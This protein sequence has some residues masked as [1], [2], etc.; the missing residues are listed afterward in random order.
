M[1]ISSTTVRNNF[2]GVSGSGVQTVFAGT[3]KITAATQVRVVQRVLSTDIESVLTNVTDYAITGVGDS[4]GFTCTLVTALPTTDNLSLLLNV[5]NTQGTQIRNTGTY[6]PNA[7][8]DAFDYR[9][10]V[11]QQQQDAISRSVKLKETFDPADYDMELPAPVAGRAIGWNDDADG[12]VNLASAGDLEVSALAETL[13]DDTTTGEMQ[14]TLGVSTYVKTI[15]DDADAAT[16][17]TTLEI[18]HEQAELILAA[19]IFS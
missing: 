10:R 1:S 4:T 19:Q 7:H 15:L 11:D 5:P 8:E 17:R 13:L 9:T 14:T 18:A 16:A 3:F 12:F 2:T 6:Y